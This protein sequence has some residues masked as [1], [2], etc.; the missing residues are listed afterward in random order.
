L[1]D[2]L[3]DL[4]L[5]SVAGVLSVIDDILVDSYVGLCQNENKG[6]TLFVV[7]MV[8]INGLY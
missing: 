1:C 6:T 5:A 8:N 4:F 2:S 3:G 7:T